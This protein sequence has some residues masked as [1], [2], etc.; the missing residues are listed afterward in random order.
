MAARANNKYTS[1][2]FN[3]ILHKDPPSSSSSSS[4]ASY[5]SVARSNGRMLVLTKS[6]PKPLRSPSTA[7][8]TTATTTTPPIS[9]A[10]RIS[11][12][13]ISDP[14]P[15]QIS[16]RP[17]GHTGPGSSLSFPIR[18][19]E[20]DKVPEV[21]APAPSSFSPKPD[22]NSHGR[23][24]SGMDR[25]DAPNRAAM[26]GSGRI[27]EQPET[28]PAPPDDELAGLMSSLLTR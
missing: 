1:I 11:N 3:H 6:S 21:P 2:N 19:P 25:P 22:R 24:I 28:D 26:R 9:P 18:T 16:L 17:L 27:R 14:D 4:S 10:P 13:A 23:D 12:Q 20:F 5:S 8:T 15:N 7:T